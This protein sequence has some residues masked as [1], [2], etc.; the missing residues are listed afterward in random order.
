MVEAD[1]GA[2]RQQRENERIISVHFVS[3]DRN[4]SA[5]PAITSVCQCSWALTR[6]TI[7]YAGRMASAAMNAYG[8]P[9][10]ALSRRGSTYR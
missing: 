10:Q 5:A 7:S 2:A 9:A 1:I 4:P 8:A 3:A 6:A